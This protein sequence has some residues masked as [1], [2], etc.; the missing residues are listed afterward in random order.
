MAAPKKK[1]WFGW[2]S[3][4]NT[5]GELITEE[6]LHAYSENIYM[7]L[8]ILHLCEKYDR[9]Q[10]DIAELQRKKLKFA[11]DDFGKTQLA[12]NDS[13]LYHSSHNLIE[14]LENIRRNLFNCG[15]LRNMIMFRLGG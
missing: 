8:E 3:K 12:Q 14:E 2:G 1:G 6:N 9:L 11:C 13:Y 4:Q 15:K 7:P 5:V 10:S